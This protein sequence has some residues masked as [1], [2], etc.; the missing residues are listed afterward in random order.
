MISTLLKRLSFLFLSGILLLCWLP[1]VVAAQAG[2]PLLIP[3]T[4]R[5][6]G[7]GAGVT[8]TRWIDPDGSLPLSYREW[9]ARFETSESF[10]IEP[11]SARGAKASREGRKLGVIVN[12]TL[13]PQI[14]SGLD[15]YIMDLTGEGYE[16]EL[17]I[18]SGG[19]P[20]DLRAFL[21]D[22]YALGLEGAVLIGDLPVPWYETDFGDP[23]EHAEF[24]CDL[25]YMDL[26]G[27]FAD[28]DS[29]EMYDMHYGAVAPEI[30]I[31]RLT[32]SPLK[33]GGESESDLV[34]YY[35]SKNHLYR[36]D[37][38]PLANRALV[39]IDDDWVPGANWWNLNVGEA[40]SNRTFVRD[41]WT[42]WGSDYLERLTQNYE[43]IQVCVHSWPGGHAFKNPA[44]DWS[45]VYIS[46]IKAIQP[47]AH[48]YNLFACSNAR[49]VEDDYCSGW[50]IFSKDFGLAAVGSAKTGSMLNFEDFYRPFGAGLSI[51]EAFRDWFSDQALGGFEEWEITWYYGM[52]LNGD[53]TLCSQKK[54]N[55]AILQFDDG[56]AQYMTTLPNGMG[57]RFNVRFTAEKECT[58]SSV[59]VT[60]IL[61]GDT[62]VRMFIWNSDGVYPAALIDSADVIA[63]EMG[64]IDVCDRNIIFEEGQDFHIGFDVLDPAPTDTLWI[65]MDDGVQQAEHRSGL[66]SGGNWL[67]LYEVWGQNYNF[68]IRA[69]VRCEPDPE[70]QITSISLPPGHTGASY[71]AALETIGGVEP[72]S[73]VISAGELPDGLAL[74]PSTGIIAGRPT[75]IGSF[76]FSVRVT[77]AGDPALTDVQHLGISVSLTCGDASGDGEI[78]LLDVLFLISYL[79]DVPPGPR[80]QPPETGDANADG[81]IDLLDVLCL[82]DFLYGSPPGS[83]PQCP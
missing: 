15:Q 55:G 70:I 6:R 82:I 57:D 46:E 31:G 13:H 62:P 49:Y 40:Y 18:N 24:P 12:A 65:Y 59:S 11:A 30:Y 33:L 38:L 58:L 83:E 42:T 63:S 2:F 3:D 36:S 54:C 44:E 16:V 27:I 81:S 22:R 52:T 66:N 7:F 32:A 69:E 67:T 1:A 76:N 39:Y 60:G 19:T 37:R 20:D 26:D 73:W 8:L 34:Q 17:Y 14:M 35:F 75:R 56:I 41:E 77:D 45:W 28:G 10:F 23:P 64:L 4:L 48:F 43:F 21:R 25:F 9:K 47:V 51:G 72:F 53:P 79:Y 50:Y 74:Y 61:T 71:E 80:P 68:L 29:D 78:N 5:N